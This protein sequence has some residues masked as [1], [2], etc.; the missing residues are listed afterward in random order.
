[1]SARLFSLASC[2][3]SVVDP[4][5][6]VGK[7]S[8]VA[9]M[10]DKQKD[11]ASI[12]FDA[13]TLGQ[14]VANAEARGDRIAICNDHAS[15]YPETRDAPALG[16]FGALAVVAE[17]KV[18]KS[19]NGA[20]DPDGLADGLY[21]RLDEVTPRG[22]DPLVG[23]A[24]Y[25]TLSPMFVTEGESE[26]GEPIGYALLDVGATNVPFQAGAEIMFHGV[27]HGT[28][29][30]KVTTMSSLGPGEAQCPICG[31]LANLHGA[32]VWPEHDRYFSP[33][34]EV[35]PPGVRCPWSGRPVVMSATPDAPR[36]FSQGASG[37]DPDTM[38]RFGIEEGD[39]DAK[40][41]E[42]MA[43]FWAGYE[44]M[45]AKCAKFDAAEAEA[46]K[47][48][49]PDGDE[50]AAMTALS[51][52]LTARGVKVPEKATR[53]TLMSLA[54]IA[55][56]PA[57]DVAA[58]VKAEV[59]RIDAERAANVEKAE[60]ESLVTMARTAKAP[61]Y[62]VQ[63]LSVLPIASAREMAQKY[64]GNGTGAPA[65]A[66][67]RVTSQGGPIGDPAARSMP[68]GEPVEV[69]RESKLGKVIEMDGGIAAKA[70]DLRDS[71]DAVVM[72]RVD[73]RAN[74]KFGRVDSFTR[75]LAAQQIAAEENPHL[76]P[77]AR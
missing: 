24:N 6:A 66:F 2:R 14:M 39:D 55:P 20:P 50:A 72:S 44:G 62:E 22:M 68:N 49:E 12:V 31:R 52:S 47:H 33:L 10:G 61:E 60:R 71:K 9:T 59:A 45:A 1:M 18:V 70:R 21:A 54:A 75:T 46:A 15:A 30:Q 76:V 28:P 8:R 57:Q 23:L 19:W 29:A 48:K 36:R 34:K 65:H 58:L 64:A 17:G 35:S 42:K 41:A 51:A 32:N 26:S 11:G 67:S 13:S 40:K 69:V 16:F 4:A 74:D 63:A 5:S 27:P 43:A 53:A 56:A 37:M 73:A 38:K 77:G 7:W 3:F 25:R